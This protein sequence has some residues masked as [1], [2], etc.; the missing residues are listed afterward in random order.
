MGDSPIYFIMQGAKRVYGYEPNKQRYKAAIKNIKLNKMSDRIKMFNTEYDGSKG[1]VLK[2][3][4]EGCE[5]S[6]LGTLKN[7][8]EVV[9]EYHSGHDAVSKVL[10]G[11]Y[12]IEIKEKDNEEGVLYARKLS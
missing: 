2:M 1:D 6:L 10:K 11:K 9:L 5:Y 8:K 7:F 12:R 4:C 3:D